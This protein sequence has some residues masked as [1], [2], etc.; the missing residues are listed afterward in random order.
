M[1]F[2]RDKINPIEECEKIISNMQNPP[3]IENHPLTLDPSD[4]CCYIPSEDKVYMVPQK[5]FTNDESFYSLFFH[6]L[7]HSTGHRKRLYREYVQNMFQLP[8]KIRAEEEIIAEFSSAI[9]CTK[10]G[11]INQTI[12][13]NSA[14]IDNWIKIFENQ[15][16][17]GILNILQQGILSAKYILNEIVQIPKSTDIQ[18]SL[19]DMVHENEFAAE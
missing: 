2:T 6:E 1:K 7:S 13:S 18:D 11:I 12:K 3:V 15:C 19:F 4:T 16:N 10:A 8:D 9:L 14:Y 17:T 5:R